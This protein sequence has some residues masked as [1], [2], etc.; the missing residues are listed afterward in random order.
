M[1]SGMLAAESIIHRLSLANPLSNSDSIIGETL[2]GK[3]IKEFEEN[4]YNSWVG[5]E[6]KVNFKKK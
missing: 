3:E 5:K 2:G 1:K 6:L 4:L